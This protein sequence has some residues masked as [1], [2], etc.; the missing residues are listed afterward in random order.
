MWVGD[1]GRESS[2]RHAGRLK[3]RA[4]RHHREAARG[5]QGAA[6]D[7]L[8]HGIAVVLLRDSLGGNARTALLATVSPDERDLAESTRTLEFVQRAKI[9]VQA[10][11]REV[12]YLS[13]AQR[14]TDGNSA[15]RRI[16]GMS[17]MQV[18]QHKPTSRRVIIDFDDDLAK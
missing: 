14:G 17:N 11:I 16:L 18:W 8:L 12:V 10:R 2:S 9:I 5:Q 1:V 15:S 6:V 4:A 13:D 7:A 3:S